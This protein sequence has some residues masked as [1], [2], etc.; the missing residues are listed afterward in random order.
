MSLRFGLVAMLLGM[1]GTTP[2]AQASSPSGSGLV[3]TGREA[4]EFLR[5]AEVV[6][7]KPIGIG[8]TKP[9]K[10]T[11]TDGERE[12]HAVWKTIDDVQ[13]GVFQGPKGGFQANYRDSYK[14]EVAA[15]ELDKLLGL[16]LVPPTVVR[17][18]D[19]RK[20]S[21][22]LWVEGAFTELDRRERNQRP[23]DYVSWSE[24][25]YKLKLLHQLIFNSD[26]RNIRNVVYDPEFRVY[27]VDHSRSFR[28]YRYLESTDELRRFSRAVLARLSALDRTELGRKLGLWLEEDE[29]DAILA[30]RD[31]LLEVAAS[32]AARLGDA[33]VLYP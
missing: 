21:L 31:L 30:R 5:N 11:L 12:L 22:Q 14:F 24:Q 29:I 4:E 32:R 9:F 27:A 15:Y 3:L 19:G 28:R 20:G 13:Q 6:G 17:V 1:A 18:I 23:E 16:G 7:M 10:A 33:A 2:A 8:I 26:S 25:L